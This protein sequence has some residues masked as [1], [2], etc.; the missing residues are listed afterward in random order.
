MVLVRIWLLL[1]AAMGFGGLELHAQTAPDPTGHWEG[2]IPVPDHPVEVIFDITRDAN[3]AL[4]GTLSQPS[5][6]VYGLL[7]QEVLLEGRTLTVIA[8]DDQPFSGTMTD[9]GKVIDGVLSAQG[10]DIPISFERMGEAKIDPPVR[11]AAV[12]ARFTGRWTSSGRLGTLT[13]DIAN[14]DDGSATAVLINEAEGG[15]RVPVRTITANGAHVTLELKA[16]SGSYEG[17]L[18]ADGTAIDGTYAQ[19]GAKA[20]LTFTKMQS[21]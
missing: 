2:Q 6:G 5:E 11:S 1:L 18:S 12:D 8:R 3:G 14:H 19:A 16:L 4:M 7:L 21:Q 9:D 17:D 15:L 10:N 13:L 20:P